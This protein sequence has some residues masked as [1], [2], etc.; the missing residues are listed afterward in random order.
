[1]TSGFFTGDILRGLAPRV[2]F[3]LSLALLPIGLIAIAQT[4]QI[5]LQ[6]QASAELSL[7]A[8]TEQAATAERRILQAAFS[9][10]EALAAI[11]Q[12]HR[13]K[14]HECSE[15]F[16]AYR[17]S[18]GIYG[19]VGFIPKSGIMTCSSSDNVYDFNE[20]P[21]YRENME[22][23]ARTAAS[24]R[25]GEDK[26]RLVTI[27]TSPVF[28]QGVFEG[29]IAMSI[30]QPTFDAVDEPPLP[31]TPLTVFTFNPKAEILT[32]DIGSRIAAAEIPR[33]AE[34]LLVGG[35][36]SHIFRAVNQGGV[37]RVYAVQPL[38]RNAAYA[39]SVWP[40][41]APFL[42]PGIA[43]KLASFLPILMWAASLIVAFWALNRLA[44]RHIRKL[45]RQM[46]RFA[47]NRNLPRVALGTSVP[48]E[49][50]DMEA[51]FISMGESILHD[52][53]QLEDSIREK[54]I[55]LKEVHHRVKNNLQLIS[56]IMN[57]Q[58]RQARSEDAS[59]VLRRLQ[60]RIL[61][62]ATVHKNL[63]QTDNLGR[64]YA[65]NLLSEVVN[66]LIR[67]GLAPGSNVKVIQEYAD[68]SLDADDAAPLTLLVSEAMT[69]A[70]K[71]VR[72]EGAGQ[73]EISVVLLQSGT[74]RAE[75][76]ISNTTG[77]IPDQ[78]GTGLGSSLITA[79]A[80]QL[81]G[82]VTVSETDS[83]YAMTINFPVPQSAKQVYDY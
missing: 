49:L 15:F 27:V 56:S 65:K 54:N 62:L 78:D 26:S 79:F 64:V 71:H 32:T 31:F 53:A 4:R 12:L 7:L 34:L 19:V 59:R 83:H 73:S 81:N 45:G 3:F 61:G 30:P 55:L 25:V 72:Q 29:F 35:E 14:P 9:A 21:I 33:Q 63:Y 47:L 75:L 40:V 80:R 43:T 17:D 48:T 6:N 11:V 16:K 23:P 8:I 41:D 50:R 5:A 82:T 76:T 70:I 58:I 74:D 66:Q 22:A 60:E 57:M 36:K 67:V 42:T 13:D 51:A 24:L 39:V 44:L 37:E 68:I 69:N 28:E 46:R 52:E 18:T 38:V 20:D 77:N 10:A 1:M 2:L